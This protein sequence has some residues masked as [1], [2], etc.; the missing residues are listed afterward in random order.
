M[1]PS[2]VSFAGCVGIRPRTGPPVDTHRRSRILGRGD[3]H[4]IAAAAGGHEAGFD[5]SAI[6]LRGHPAPHDPSDESRLVVERAM[7]PVVRPAQ[8][9]QRTC[10]TIA[11]PG[12]RERFAAVALSR[13]A[14]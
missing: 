5:F 12:D 6:R 3:T 1:L 8:D 7:T 2:G 9:I 14:Q 11:V 10:V 4:Y 13:V